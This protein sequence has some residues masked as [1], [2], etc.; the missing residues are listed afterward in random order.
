[1]QAKILRLAVGSMAVVLS[2]F[3]SAGEP[4][5]IDAPLAPPR[6]AVDEPLISKFSLESAAHSLDSIALNW[7]KTKQCAACHTLPPYLMARPLL[8]SVSPEPRDVRQFFER[9]VEERLEA[10]PDLPKDGISAIIIQTAAF[11]AASPGLRNINARAGVGSPLHKAGPRSITSPT[12]A[13]PTVSWLYKLAGR[14]NR[15]SE[16]E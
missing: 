7:Q 9:I 3:A 5:E 15:T 14:S 11:A 2:S 10:E 16:V 6:A 8:K 1:M 4:G 13:P 12:L